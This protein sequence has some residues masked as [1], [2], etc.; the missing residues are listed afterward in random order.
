MICNST[1]YMYMLSCHANAMYVQLHDAV[2]SES[3][4]LFA[5]DQPTDD[6]NKTLDRA[7]A[8]PSPKAY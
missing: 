4:K 6:A 2:D 8:A 3:Y 5:G 1:S 7:L